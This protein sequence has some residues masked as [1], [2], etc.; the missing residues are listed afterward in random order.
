[1]HLASTGDALSY[2]AMLVVFDKTIT[3][4][5]NDTLIF[6]EAFA[7]FSSGTLS[8]A[9]GPGAT[10]NFGEI[11]VF[12]DPIVNLSYTDGLGRILQTQT[13]DGP[14]TGMIVSQTLY[15]GWGHP[16]VQTKPMR[17]QG[18]DLRYR[19]DVVS[20]FDWTSG[21]MRGAVSD[22]YH[23]AASQGQDHLFPYISTV[24]EPNPLARV[25]EIGAP[26]VEFKAGS[27]YLPKNEFGRTVDA[28]ALLATLGLTNQQERFPSVTTWRALD[29]ASRTPTTR[30]LDAQRNVVAVRHDAGNNA[31]LSTHQIEYKDDGTLDLSAYPPNFHRPP[32]PEAKAQ[33][34]SLAKT[35]FLGRTTLRQDCDSATRRFVYDSAGRLRFM[36]DGVGATESPNRISYWKYDALGRVVEDG[37]VLQGW[38]E[39]QLQNYADEQPAWPT[40]AATWRH[41]YSY[42]LRPNNDVT[43]TKGRVHQIVTRDDAGKETREFYVY[44][45][46]GN[47][48]AKQLQVDAYDGAP[49]TTQYE[50]DKL[51]NVV[52][53]I[54]PHDPAG[55]SSLE[56]NY[57]YDA[58]GKLV[59]VGT[60]NQPTCYAAYD[61][62]ID[63]S[64][65]T[66]WLNNNALRCDFRYDFQ[67]RL[68]AIKDTIAGQPANVN[69]LFSESLSYRD[70]TGNFKNGNITQVTFA[71]TALGGEQRYAYEYDEHSR[72][73]SAKAN[74][75]ADWNIERI[76]YDANS[77]ITKI[78]NGSISSEYIYKPG[79]NQI[80]RRKGLAGE[81]GYL[82]DTNGR[83]TQKI[84]ELDSK[85]QELAR[86]LAAAA[87]GNESMW[88]LADQETWN[89]LLRSTNRDNIGRWWN[90]PSEGD[91]VDLAIIANVPC[92]DLEAVDRL[93]LKYSSGRF[94]FSVQR[95]IYLE[96]GAP[97]GVNEPGWRNF[98]QRV[99]WY[100]WDRWVMRQEVEF[101]SSA[102]RGCFPVI[103]VFTV[104]SCSDWSVAL[105]GL[106]GLFSR[107]EACRQ[108]VSE[109]WQPDFNYQE[110]ARLLAA[111][112]NGNESMWQLAD[113]ETWNILLRSTNRDNIGRWWNTPSEGDGVDLA[114]IANVPCT[115]LEAV[116]RLWLKYSSGRFGFSVQR[117]IYLEFG[118]P[119]GVNEPGW[120]NFGQR[121][122]WYRWDRWVMRQEV[123]F[124]SSAPRGCFPV[125]GVFTVLSCSDWSVAL[126]GLGGL[127][128][129]LEA[130][131]GAGVNQVDRIS[132]EPFTTLTSEIHKRDVI[133][134]FSYDGSRQR[135]LKTTCPEGDRANR[136]QTLYVHGI[137][138][139]PLME[140]S[141]RGSVHYIYGLTGLI[142][143]HEDNK[144]FFF[145]KDH[146]GSTRVVLNQTNEVEA[147]FDYAT[148]G[149]LRVANISS[150]DV[151]AR[152]RYL[153][154]GQEFDWETGLYNYRARLYDSDLARFYSPD[155][156]NE[157]FSPYVFV[158][159]DPI[160]RVDPSGMISLLGARLLTGSVSSLVY[161]ILGAGLGA[162]LGA[163][164]GAIMGAAQGNG[165]EQTRQGAL[166]GAIGGIVGGA[167]AG[168]GLGGFR[169]FAESYLVP[170]SRRGV[171]NALHPVILFNEHQTADILGVTI[172]QAE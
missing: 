76:T 133:T 170:A 131:R 42:D 1:M 129:R 73:T 77:N 148:F 152:F 137:N 31:V 97:K 44:D 135:V 112:A 109:T 30:V 138:R 48:A 171:A 66:E 87:N 132:Y 164:I 13:I 120:R 64:L 167:I 145:L 169:I 98:G 121:V 34:R 108:K 95:D 12:Y 74:M 47:V 151:T 23:T 2:S 43:H 83:L 29:K 55:A 140:T 162:G 85:Y 126:T 68:L 19:D 91:G 123:E 142:A 158:G 93:W 168:L 128:S 63:G 139:H 134:T 65:K 111:A 5:L 88:Q 154:T 25:I 101:V 59:G 6:S 118:A 116:D 150:K 106:G 18:I 71:G 60:A 16:A 103:G 26:G 147:K 153:Y 11:S 90:T 161:T 143:M 32:N 75:Q 92:T 102:P 46:Y 136:R 38:N 141:D 159:N 78:D 9:P 51:G 54:Y 45:I 124:V 39:D 20:T 15:D 84:S 160:N 149:A 36:L 10:I 105:T 79:T 33:Y 127:F 110:L 56:V 157:F 24:R 27:P 146:L 130:C 89:I 62:D 67:G 14:G 49:R 40:P 8:I 35:G 156:L 50:Y 82:Y 53:I 163:A 165:A 107:L 41:R 58:V 125:I 7:D 113:Q 69:A 117:D 119:K 80:F 172:A 122:G 115:D 61:Y 28:T 81:A 100:R 70:T 96:F 104:L 144:S 72:L 17:H 57:H 114:I 86:L 22:Y 155:P 4:F 52:K 99:G 37:F 166:W 21:E 94:G 3:F